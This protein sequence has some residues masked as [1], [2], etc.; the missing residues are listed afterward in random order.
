MWLE[1]CQ[2]SK[3]RPVRRG[4]VRE[5]HVMEISRTDFIEEIGN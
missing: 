1:L 3:P 5:D 4:K 2:Q